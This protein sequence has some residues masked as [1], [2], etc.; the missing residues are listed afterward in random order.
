MRWWCVVECVDALWRSIYTPFL[1]SYH[2]GFHLRSASTDGGW[3]W[4]QKKLNLFYFG[5]TFLICLFL[6]AQHLHIT[7]CFSICC[8]FCRWQRSSLQNGVRESGITERM[9]HIHSKRISLGEALWMSHV[10]DGNTL[11]GRSY[12]ACS[13]RACHRE[14][15]STQSSSLSLETSVS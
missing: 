6:S 13:L 7:H 3:E 9:K 15:L 12:T 11:D 5:Y 14:K 8:W 4:V 1:R 10:R 2:R